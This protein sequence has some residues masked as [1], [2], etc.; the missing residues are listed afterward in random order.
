MACSRGVFGR[1]PDL[2][3]DVLRNLSPRFQGANLRA[4]VDLSE[5]LRMVSSEL[6]ATT[7]QAAIAWVAARGGDIAPLIG[8]RTRSRLAEALGSIDLQLAE[9][10]LIRLSE[11]VP[12]GAASGRAFPAHQR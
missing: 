6:H 1:S 2:Q 7:A 12:D 9:R 10:E 11:I 3:P 5:R 4:N 8:A